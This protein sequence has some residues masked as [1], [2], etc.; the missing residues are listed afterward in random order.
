[1][2]INLI[3][4]AVD[5]FYQRCFYFYEK[6]GAR[7]KEPFLGFIEGN[8]LK[9]PLDETKNKSCRNIKL[10]DELKSILIEMRE[11]R[12]S[13]LDKG[14]EK[15]AQNRAYDMIARKLNR[16]IKKLGFTGKCL[17]LKSFRHTYGIV[18][19]HQT[20]DI[21]DVSRKMGHSSVSTTHKY[22]EFEPDII[23]DDFPEFKENKVVTETQKL[24]EDN[25]QTAKP[26][27]H[28]LPPW[29]SKDEGNVLRGTSQRG[30][31]NSVR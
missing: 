20:K 4:D 9:I 8:W 28:S 27:I 16:T 23:H 17:S 7:A 6:T 10:T 15:Y 24:Q 25:P 18:R 29:V 14:D 19:V 2:E 30:M 31:G 3:H 5:E 21:F 22:L 12:D 13:Y 26:K 1:M 11:F